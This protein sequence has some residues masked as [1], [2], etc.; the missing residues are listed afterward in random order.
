MSSTN[1]PAERNFSA[2]ECGTY[3]GRPVVWLADQFMADAG[4]SVKKIDDQYEV[5]RVLYQRLKESS[6]WTHADAAEAF[7]VSVRTAEGMSLGR[8]SKVN[9]RKLAKMLTL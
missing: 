4:G 3:R 6:G 7:G 1:D 9:R 5:S 2:V 8:I